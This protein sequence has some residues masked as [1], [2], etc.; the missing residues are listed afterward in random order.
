[1]WHL[2]GERGDLASDVPVGM[3]LMVIFDYFV[4][5]CGWVIGVSEDRLREY[6]RDMLIWG[7]ADW[8]VYGVVLDP[9]Q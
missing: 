3:P 4:L 6:K 8:R 5:G 7:V 9:P 2:L 1:M